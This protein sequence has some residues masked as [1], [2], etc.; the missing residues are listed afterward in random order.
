MQQPDELI[1][2]KTLSCSNPQHDRSTWRNPIFKL[3]VLLFMLYIFFISIS[4]IG[5]AF[6]FFGKNLAEQLITTT[7]N[8]LVGLVIGILATT[9]IQSSST[10]TSIVVG[11]VGA[12]V[13]T[14]TNA[15]PI[16][17]GANIGTSVTNTLVSIGHITRSGEFKRAFAASTV[18]DF[19]NILAVLILF[20]VQYFT[21][22]LGIGSTFLANQF[23]H[24]GGLK[25]SSPIK[26]ITAPVQ[27]IIEQLCG[28]SGIIILLIAIILLFTALKFLVTTLRSIFAGKIELFFD[29]YIFKTP[30]RGL[31]FGII[32]T[33]LVQS[34]SITTSMAVPL[35]GAG[36]LTLDQIFPYTLGANIGTT[37]TAFLASLA[38][39]NVAAIAVA[40]A[41][42]LFN[43][44]GVIIIYPIRFIPLY[45]ANTLAKFSIKSKL[46]PLFYILLIF[47]IIPLSIIYLMR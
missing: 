29:K 15:I 6:K 37:I 39:N 35:A 18:H 8:P 31:L 16:I 19:F 17:M 1:S 43:I 40:F 9:L 20:P 33:V 44:L 11:L 23:Q 34:S 41:H 4:L 47:Y 36:I 10:T 3:L 22:L 25:F 13:L 30:L 38:T 24:I 32:T 26:I 21:N 27:H 45:L 5:S 7:S 2:Q 12:G 28:Y 46:I 14:V 42:L